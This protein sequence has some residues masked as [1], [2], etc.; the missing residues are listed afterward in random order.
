MWTPSEV[1]FLRSLNTPGKIQSYLDALIYNPEDAALSPRYVMLSGDGHCFEGCLLAAAAL[2]LQGHPPLL[3]DLLGHHDD[4][5]VI[6]VYKTRSGW[7]SLGKSN[8]TLLR[9][10]NP[11][12]K[13]IHELVMSYFPFYFNTKGQPSLYGYSE[14]INLNK[15]NSWNWRWS[16]ENLEDMG[17]NFCDIPHFEILSKKELSK[18]PRVSQSLMDACF[19][20]ADKNGLYKA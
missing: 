4:D 16:D 9:G 8:T 6:C 13:N 7:G 18:L 5:H 19:L 12:F 11:V 10:R 14:P 3:V 1:K 15:F 20:G 17:K 2:E